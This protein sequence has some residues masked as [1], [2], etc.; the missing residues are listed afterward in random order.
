VDSAGGV[1]GE[2]WLRA[3]WA[4]RRRQHGY[5]GGRRLPVGRRASRQSQ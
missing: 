5:S 2:E 3:L 1:V 4:G